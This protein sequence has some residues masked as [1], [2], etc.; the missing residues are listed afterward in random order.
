[1]SM[2]RER[3]A[4]EGKQIYQVPS[5]R[6]VRLNANSVQFHGSFIW[7]TVMARIKYR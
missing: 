6:T 2:P 1:M 5:T 4:R 7:Q 3:V